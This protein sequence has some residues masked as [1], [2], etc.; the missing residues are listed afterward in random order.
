MQIQQQDQSLSGLGWARAVVD[1]P[2]QNAHGPWSLA[3]MGL[4]SYRPAGPPTRPVVV[5]GDSA[6]DFCLFYAL[7]RLVGAAW[8]LPSWLRKDTLYMWRLNHVLDYGSART[9]GELLATSASPAPV[10]DELVATIRAG[11]ENPPLVRVVSAEEALPQRPLR[12]FERDNQGRPQ[13]RGLI[14]GQRLA[15]TTPLPARARTRP[16]TAMRWMVDV[17]SPEWQPLR[18]PALGPAL[19]SAPMYSADTCRTT[20]EGIAY[21]CPSPIIFT[22]EHLESAVAHPELAP[23]PLLEQLRAIATASD[24]HVELSDK[25]AYAAE[26]AALFGGSKSLVSALREESPRAILDTYL[27]DDESGAPG[28][29]LRQDGPLERHWETGPEPIWFYGLA[30]VVYQLLVHNGDL[31]LLAVAETFNTS[32]PLEQTYE[33]DVH[34]DTAEKGREVDLFVSEGSRLWIGDATV[35][36]DFSRKRL[37]ELRA[38]ARA[39]GAHGILLVT[40]RETFPQG[41]RDAVDDVFSRLDYP[42]LRLITGVKR[43][44]EDDAAADN[45]ATDGD[46]PA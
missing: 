24:G 27:Q 3:A 44:A 30:E 6:W 5:F 38:I 14:D 22:G 45:A 43:G 42:S 23:L 35:T 25:G 7:K 16:E 28:R 46:V 39:F 15:L 11:S 26:S 10:S 33:L 8:W 29:W 19:L 20:N 21:A 37:Q 36:G 13:S 9:G 31:P 4:D 18:R 40:S 12:I 1:P 17:Y 32:R 2:E 34:R 41:T